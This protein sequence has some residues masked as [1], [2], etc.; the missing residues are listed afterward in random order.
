MSSQEEPFIYILCILITPLP[1]RDLPPSVIILHMFTCIEHRYVPLLG[2][3]LH[4]P[5]TRLLLAMYYKAL[6]FF[7]KIFE[8][9]EKVQKKSKNQKSGQ[10]KMLSLEEVDSCHLQIEHCISHP[11]VGL[12]V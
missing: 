1:G 7:F 12:L 9:S 4:S 3:S 5:N 6:L 2:T 8:I 10:E 11:L